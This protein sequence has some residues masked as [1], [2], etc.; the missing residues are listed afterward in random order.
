VEWGVMT[1]RLLSGTI[2]VALILALLA[3]CERKPQPPLVFG[4]AAWPGYEPVYLA[5]ELGYFSATNLQLSDYSGISE[6]KQALRNRSVQ[7][8]ALPL[9][10]ALLLRRDIPNLKIILLFDAAGD[11]AS[12][13]RIDVLV[14]RDETIGQYHRE[15][16]A[17]VQGWHRAL[18]YLHQEHAK[19][20]QIMARHE[21]LT[22]AQ[23]D[24]S[25]QAIELYDL[26]RNQQLMIGE[27]PAIGGDIVTVQRS[28]LNRGL[29]NFGEDP[30]MLVDATLLAEAI[31]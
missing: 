15:M 22:S 29:L 23:F 31:K 28:M 14:T 6:L 16:Q 24:K 30:S 20:V 9:D 5:R 11:A 7:L 8:A 4:A 26:R 13:R 10:E 1:K 2:V 12:G 19:A 3:A 17:L 25:L 21:H 18:E 27:P